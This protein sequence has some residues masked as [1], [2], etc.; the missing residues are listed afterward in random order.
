MFV[1]RRFRYLQNPCTP[2]WTQASS[3]QGCDLWQAQESWC[4]PVEADQET[5][6]GC[7]GEMWIELRVV[8][9]YKEKILEISYDEL[10]HAPLLP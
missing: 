8:K 4:Q 1:R 10:Y 7:R 9:L 6:I 2:W 3:S 5:A